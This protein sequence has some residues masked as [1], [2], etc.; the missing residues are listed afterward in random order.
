MGKDLIC[1][2][3]SVSPAERNSKPLPI[4]SP[5]C[6]LPTKAEE[7]VLKLCPCADRQ[8]SFSGRTAEP[9]VYL[10]IQRRN[11]E[12]STTA[13]LPSWFLTCC[14]QRPQ[15]NQPFS[16]LLWWITFIKEACIPYHMEDRLPGTSPTMLYPHS[17][18]SISC[19]SPYKE[20]NTIAATVCFCIT[21][22]SVAFPLLGET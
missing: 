2:R 21:S 7:S 10:I 4:S 6:S 5:V 12:T 22:E 19:L 1:P 17:L 9:R 20:D 16:V 14:F 13:F 8:A 15:F 3:P 11:T 18:P